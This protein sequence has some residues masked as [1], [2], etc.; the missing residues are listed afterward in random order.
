[1]LI[2]RGRAREAEMKD[3]LAQYFGVKNVRIV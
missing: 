3:I 1:M 2:G